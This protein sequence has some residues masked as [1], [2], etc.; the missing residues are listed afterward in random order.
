MSG[1]AACSSCSSSRRDSLSGEPNPPFKGELPQDVYKYSGPPGGYG[2]TLALA[3]PDDPKTYNIVLASDT[4]TADVLWLN[5]FRCPVDYRNAGYKPGDKPTYDPGLCTSWDVSADAKQWTF[6]LRRGV[7]WSDGED[8][9]ADDLMFSY[10]VLKD[11]KVES[12]S[13]DIFIEGIGEDGKPI[14]PDAVKVD[15]HTVR[16]DLHQA[17]FNFL[18]SIFNL[19]LIPRHKWEGAWR[20]GSFRETMKLTD[21]PSSVVSLG[22]FVVK[23]FVTGQRVVLERNPYYWKVDSE[24]H[25]LPYLDRLVFLIAKDFN[26]VQ[27]KFE[28]G[29]ID[30]MPRVRPQDYEAVKRLESD[31]IKLQ[32][33]GVSYDTNWLAFNQNLGHND[34]TGKPYVEPWKLKLFRDQKFRQAISYA[35]DREGIANTVYSARGVPIYAFVTPGDPIWFSKDVM[36]YPYDPGRARQMLADL[37]LKDTNGDGILEDSEGH[38]LEITM[39]V[40]SSNSQRVDSTAFIARNLRDIGIKATPAPVAFNVTI[41][42]IER[43]FDFDAVV[44]GWQTNPPSGLTNTKN[45]LLSS[46]VQHVCFPKQKKPSSE[47]EARIDELT[48]S[49]ESKA[50]LSERQKIYAEI[51]RIWSEQLP[52]INIVA[53]REAVAYRNKFGNLL[54][55]ALPPRVLWNSEEIYQKR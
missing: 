29:E 3:I 43:R 9:N 2:G 27:A 37:G 42:M 18:D 40:N 12:P 31:S 19:W 55:S 23:E 24:G 26:T 8:F 33:I 32:D 6:H 22:P 39:Y 30:L 1:A 16:F 20:T 7:K 35:I 4:A 48:Y 54:P 13:R 49:L 17:N 46:G 14:F 41:D 51:Q 10:D 53:A 15:D 36:T 21:G 34:K 5:V 50:E 25:R 47:W 11:E 52:E 28:A 45:I 44:L 38:P